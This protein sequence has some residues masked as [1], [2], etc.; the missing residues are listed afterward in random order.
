LTTLK[1]ATVFLLILF[2]YRGFAQRMDATGS[3]ISVNYTVLPTHSFKDT[4]GG[5]GFNAV[6]ANI[7]IPLFGNRNKIINNVVQD[8]TPHFYQIATHEGFEALYSTIGFIQTQRTF[9]T[10][11]AGLG[12]L[13]YNGK[14]NV[15]LV[16]ASIG[17][18]SDGLTIQ[19]NDQQYRFSGS[20]IV[21]HIHSTSTSYL[22]GIVLTY[23]YGRPLPLPVLGIHTK[24]SKSWSFSAILPVS[25]QFT[26]RFNKDMSLAFGIRPSGNRF[27]FQNKNDFDSSTSSTVYM[28]LRQFQ[29]AATYT[30][31]F[32]KSFSF[33]AEAGLLA[34]GNLKFTEQNDRKIILS[35]EDVKAGTKFRVSLRYHLPRKKITGN[36]NI[37]IDNEM[38]RM[39]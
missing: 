17:I 28:Q 39:Y 4:T 7:N 35:Q 31:R 36:N 13:F 2:S 6:G 9:Y 21:N 12:G 30:Y 38:F 27:Q 10:A 26:D 5:F 20:F 18:A 14:K 15:F 1:I 8:G 32:S 16:D 3:S 22:Y 37:D 19:N 29:L 23:A 25:I 24:F 33:S 11:S 34:G